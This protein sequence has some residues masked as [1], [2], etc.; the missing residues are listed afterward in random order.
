MQA[1]KEKSDSPLGVPRQTPAIRLPSGFP[2]RAASVSPPTSK[3]F[4]SPFA[5]PLWC[6]PAR[7]LPAAREL[8]EVAEGSRLSCLKLLNSNLLLLLLCYCFS[9]S[10]QPRRSSR[11]GQIG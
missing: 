6:R 2:A 9:C 10:T 7:F 1:G 11:H 8:F 4:R 3:N 5:S